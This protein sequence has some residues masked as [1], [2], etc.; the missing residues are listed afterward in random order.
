MSL[1]L[2]LSAVSVT[3]HS[4]LTWKNAGMN[5]KT[6]PEQSDGASAKETKDKKDK[7]IVDSSIQP[8]TLR[9][10]LLLTL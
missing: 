3:R 10:R 1:H 4:V 2:A 9:K 5:I 6:E 8:V 7:P